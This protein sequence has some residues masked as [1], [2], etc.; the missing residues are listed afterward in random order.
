MTTRSTTKPFT[1]EYLKAIGINSN[2]TQGRG[3]NNPVDLVVSKRDGRI[4]ILNRGYPA[5]SRIGVINLEEEYFHDISA[6]GDDDGQINLPT[7]V[8]MDS[9]ERVYVTEERNHRV[10]IFDSSGPFLGKWGERGSGPGQFEGPSGLA[11]DADD[12]AFVV[13]QNNHRV[14]KFTADGRFLL[15][16]GEFGT[17]DGQF[18]LPWGVTVD[19]QGYVYVADWRNDRIQ[20]FSRDGEFVAKFG[21]SGT[22]DGQFHRPSSVA[23]D[24]ERL[25]YVADWGNERVQV[26]GPD[27]GFLW[28]ERGRAG[29]SKW[30]AEF[31]AAN[32]DEKGP[33]DQSNLLPD[34]PPHLDSPYLVSSQT[35]SYFWGPA[36]VNLDGEG[37][38]YVTESARHRLQVFAASR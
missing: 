31:F 17:A 36:S 1:L 3:F 6:N 37:R 25:I 33:R 9:R 13:D 22:G 34:L 11:F 2:T 12:N 26:L 20:K 28:N 19:S 14:E 16:W 27:G 29:I 7:A 4:F 8:A 30:A 10:S 21:S 38:L 18:N 35:E 5:S 24:D 15:E 23:V 32:P